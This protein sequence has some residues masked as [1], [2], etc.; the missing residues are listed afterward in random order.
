MLGLY[1]HV[2]YFFKLIVLYACTHT[3]TTVF[4]YYFQVVQPTVLYVSLIRV[5]LVRTKVTLSRVAEHFR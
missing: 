1:V 4:G 2:L 5:R 3:H